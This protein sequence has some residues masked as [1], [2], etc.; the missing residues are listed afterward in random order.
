MPDAAPAPGPG[1][2]SSGADRRIL[3][4]AVAVLRSDGYAGLTTAKVAARAGHNKGLIAYHYG[5]KQGLVAAA[6]KEVAESFRAEFLAGIAVPRTLEELARELAESMWRIVERD[7][8]LARIYFDLASQAVVDPEVRAVSRAIE[9]RHREMV[10][11][12]LAQVDDGP[13]PG[14]RSAAAVYLIASLE[15]LMLARLHWG[16]DRVVKQA[17]EMFVR[18][19]RAGVG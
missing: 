18:S 13:S 5:S 17:R 16:S 10:E 3:D 19:V 11:E 1:R 4:A 15:G 12:L 2:P 9:D 14:R 8:G 7:E 6:A